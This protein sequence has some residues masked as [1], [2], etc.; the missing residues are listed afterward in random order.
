MSESKLAPAHSTAARQ[1]PTAA[2]EPST[3]AVVAGP[4]AEQ[5]EHA[6]ALKAA[7]KRGHDDGF[8]K[9][10]SEGLVGQDAIVGMPNG[11]L[12]PKGLVTVYNLH[13]EMLH[14]NPATIEAHK[15]AGWYLPDE[16]PP[17]AHRHRRQ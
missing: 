8:E 2:L 7:Y 9:G 10:Y 3:P 1:S 15:D 16:L 12:A 5:I 13:G 17:G 11:A 14:I 4:T 6:A